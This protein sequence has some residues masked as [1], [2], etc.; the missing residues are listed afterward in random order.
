MA[1]PNIHLRHERQL[2]GWSQ[3][4][5]AE[6]IHAPA[7]YIS[8]WERG[9]VSPSPYYQQ[10]LCELFGST[11]EQLGFL[12][13]EKT[14][15][16][17]IELEKTHLL[18]NDVW[19]RPSTLLVIAVSRSWM[20]RQ[21]AVLLALLLFLL[22]GMSASGLLASP[23]L[24]LGSFSFMSSGAGTVN[25][26]E[27][28]ANE[29]A[30][31]VHLDHKS[32]AG[33][34][35]EA[36]L[37]PDQNNPEGTIIPLGELSQQGDLTYHDPTHSNLLLNHSALLV[38]EQHDVPTPQA[39]SLDQAD[40]RYQVVIN[41]HDA[42]GTPYSLLDHFRHLFAID[43]E[44]EAVGLHGGL[45]SWLAHNT[46]QL[47]LLS[48]DAQNQRYN[49]SVLHQ[50]LLRMLEYLDGT[51]L[52]GQDLSGRS[53]PSNP[54]AEIGLLTLFPEQSNPGYLQHIE[55]HLRGIVTSPGVSNRQQILANQFLMAIDRI[56]NQLQETRADLLQ[57]LKE[58]P[59]PSLLISMTEQVLHASQ[60]AQLVA[61][62]MGQ[63][64][65]FEIFP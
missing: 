52:I 58:N 44:V 3:A 21:R 33:M 43:P 38:T 16:A 65:T 8:R 62:N 2:R 37:L 23:T 59:P 22:L 56:M 63:L 55:N 57:L 11:A 28:M 54:Q 10:K 50:D 34:G 24:P 17:P 45:V 36:W 7:R 4:Y 31:R 5:L 13:L 1:S 20:R 39:P 29:I 40:W 60:S 53:F 19:R 61:A 46:K 42:P 14:L 48:S 30:L 35:Y 47:A 25:S 32:A 27:G 12:P 49:A 9:E 18:S 15:N 6:Q 64:L 26:S 41:Q 51:T